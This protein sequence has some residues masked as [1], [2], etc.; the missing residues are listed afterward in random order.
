MICLYVHIH[1]DFCIH[2]IMWNYPSTVSDLN[3]GHTRYSRT[4][5]KHV[6]NTN[7]S[8]MNPAFQAIWRKYPEAFIQILTHDQIYF[9][10]FVSRFWGSKTASDEL[11][12]ALMCHVLVQHCVLYHQIISNPSPFVARKRRSRALTFLQS[13]PLPHRAVGSP[14]WRGQLPLA[15]ILKCPRAWKGRF[16]ANDWQCLQKTGPKPKFTRIRALN[17]KPFSE[18]H[19]KCRPKYHVAIGSSLSPRFL[20]PRSTVSFTGA[21]KS[22]A[23]LEQLQLISHWYTKVHKVYS[24]P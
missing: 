8:G 20:R 22:H 14:N 19:Q 18:F 4:C 21:A 24:C 7:Y 16:G 17:L 13:E 23:P 3:C 10:G 6:Y 2:I 5:P 9:V 11:L 12:I 15:P 1:E